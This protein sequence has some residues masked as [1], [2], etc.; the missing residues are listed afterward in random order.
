MIWRRGIR[1]ISVTLGVILSASLSVTQSGKNTQTRNAPQHDAAAIIKLVTVRV[2]DPEGHPVT[3]LK[4]E[5]FVLYDNGEKRVITEFEIHTLSDAGMVVLPKAEAPDPDKSLE[6]MNRRIFIFLDIQ[7]SDVS[8][9]ANAKEAALHFVDTQL[10][11]SDEVGILV[12]SPT[13][14]FLIQEYLTTDHER[15]REAIKK[16]KDIEGMPSSGFVSAAGGNDSVRDRSGRSGGPGSEGGSGSMGMGSGGT[17][18]F[19]YSGASIS[20]AVPGSSRGH[21]GDFVPQMFD[22]T[23]A[24]KYIP[25]NKS[26]I[27]F[28][29]RTLG[30]YA[31]KLGKEFASASTPVYT[32]NTRN[33]MRKGVWTSYK[34]KHIYGD[35]PLQDLALASGG[36]Y[37]A[38]IKDVE[39]IARDVQALTGNFYVLGYYIDERWDGE[40]HEIEVKVNQ[41]GLQ[42]LA[43]HGYFNPRPYGEL[44]EFQKKL[45]LFDLVFAEKNPSTGR[46]DFPIE[47]LLISGEEN[48]N[49]V[50]LALLS[51]NEKT[52]I[53]PSL[54]EIFMLIFNEDQKV[55]EEMNGTIDFSPFNNKILVPYFP[56]NLPEGKYECRMV[57]R[58]LGTGQS[59]IGRANFDVSDKKDAK[60][61]MAS[62]LLFTEGRD[63]QIFKFSKKP[64]RKEK[65]IDFSLGDIYKY[66]PE[67]YQLVVGEIT[68]DIENLLAVLPV[69]FKAGTTPE[70]E[71]FAS[72]QL[73]P[74]GDAIEIPMQVID[75][76]TVRKDKDIVILELKLPDLAPGVYEL[77]IEA[78]E[79]NTSALFSV[80]KSLIKR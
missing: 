55:V 65:E 48:T 72:F 32:I 33:W 37:F 7:G 50:L 54:V 73:K 42:V 64:R 70:V 40:Y 38:D 9:M 69:S 74:E 19:G 75:V 6:R 39:A 26:L 49:C 11:P 24:L 15:I 59:S 28:T 36:K 77:E 60:I 18:P 13:R 12:F 23:Q 17:S 63:S 71:F 56:G 80:R 14:G 4:K 58:D 2:L 79:R 53:P 45:H 29:A 34:Q 25:G 16:T 67:K 8:G 52:G 27:I 62:P 61:V 76:Q 10:H 20:T 46:L 3:D 41:P 51:V 1:S 57:T 30:P 22:L 35:H 47:A 44:T 21:R 31:A 43:Q 68:A 66:L 78:Y 5:D